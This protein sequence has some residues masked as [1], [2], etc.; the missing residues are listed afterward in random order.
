MKGRMSKKRVTPRK[1]GTPD[2]K[3][4]TG[5]RA[6]SGESEPASDEAE[7]ETREFPREEPNGRCLPKR[8]GRKGGKQNS[9]LDMFSVEAARL[10]AHVFA[11]KYRKQAQGFLWH[12]AKF[13]NLGDFIKI[14]GFEREC[15]KQTGSKGP[16][17]VRVIWTKS[18]QTPT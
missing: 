1:K 6:G 9:G 4:S 14:A 18:D 17:E 10:H 2:E 5:S 11:K 7:F 12:R 16:R 3:R 13:L 8:E 15:T